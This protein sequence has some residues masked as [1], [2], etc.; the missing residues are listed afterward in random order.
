M[1]TILEISGGKRGS[2]AKKDTET[3]MIV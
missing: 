3:L 2:T 1:N